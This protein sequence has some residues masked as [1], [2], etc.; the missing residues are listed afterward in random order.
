MTSPLNP[1]VGGGDPYRRASGSKPPARDVRDFH[2]N[3]D[4][5][6]GA[7]AQHHTLGPNENQASNGAHLHDGKNSKQIALSDI[8]KTA[9]TITGAKGGNAALTSLLTQLQSI[10]LITDN[11]T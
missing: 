3:S 2:T 6:A 7:Q 1:S 8:V 11:T 4:L 10:G 5:D 9:P